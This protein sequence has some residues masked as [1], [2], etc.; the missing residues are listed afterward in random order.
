MLQGACRGW[1]H[2][3]HVGQAH[4]VV[5]HLKPGGE[6]WATVRQSLSDQACPAH[7]ACTHIATLHNADTLDCPTDAN[8]CY[9]D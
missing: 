6:L 8:A 1:P 4:A 7:H 5:Q 2:G 3:S 9:S